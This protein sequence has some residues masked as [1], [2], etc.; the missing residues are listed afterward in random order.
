MT[1]LVLVG[2]PGS[3]KGTQG[4]RLAADAQIPHV[5]TGDLL[6]ELIQSESAEALR[7]KAIMASGNLIPDEDIVKLVDE[8]LNR[9]DA[10]AGY[11]LDGFPRTL[12]QAE[13]FSKTQPGKLLDKVIVLNV[14]EDALVERLAGRLTCLSCGA[15][16]HIK[17]LPPKV[18]GICDNC[19]AELV[20]RQDDNP[21]SIKQRLKVYQD[22]TSP[23]IEFFRPLG[24]V[25][26]IDAAGAPN[27]VYA[28]LKALIS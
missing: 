11:L 15:S 8:R 5:A 17:N 3:G 22:L 23:V 16:F 28:K 6:R 25:T 26:E 27:E 20:Q 4:Q 13:L 7:F 2:P 21:E 1:R 18:A 19:G 9:S 12:K 24:L 14:D 10:S